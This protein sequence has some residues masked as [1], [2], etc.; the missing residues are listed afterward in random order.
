MTIGT[1][2][3]GLILLALLALCAYVGPSQHGTVNATSATGAQYAGAL[4]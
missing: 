1:R 3:A 4:P 2:T